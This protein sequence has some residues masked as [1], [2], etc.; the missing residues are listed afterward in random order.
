MAINV[1]ITRRFRPEY[2][3]EALSHIAQ[4]RA[5]ATVQEGYLSGKS[6]VSR[7]DPHKVIVISSWASGADWERWH[8]S[9][10]RRDYYKKLRLTLAEPEV[11]EVFDVGRKA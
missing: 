7:E 10:I 3:H 11:V 4:L 6:L 1:L 8:V 5:L 2:L 9:D